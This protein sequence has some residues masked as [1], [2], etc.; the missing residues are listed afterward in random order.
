MVGH[1]AP[2]V[3][4]S[5]R[6]HLQAKGG[7]EPLRF[8]HQGNVVDVRDVM[9]RNDGLLRHVTEGGQFRARLWVERRG[10]P[11]HEDVGGDA[12][13]HE[14]LDGVLGGLGFL[15][16]HRPHH[17]NEGDV[18]EGHVVPADAELE[19]PEGL[20]VRGGFDVADGAA[21]LDDAH[22]RLETGVVAA[23]VRDGLDPIHDGVRDVW[24]D[25]N[26]FAEVIAAPFGFDDFRV[27]LSR[28]QVVVTSEV[29]IEE[30]LV[31]SKVEIDFPAV[32]EHEDL[33]VLERTHRSCV[34]VE[35]GVDF[36]GGDP[37]AAGFHQHANAAR[38]DAFTESAEDAT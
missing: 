4:E 23:L 21:Q 7:A 28:G 31:I 26:G 5:V 19:L 18:H 36:D 10:G 35:I 22:L 30:A 33:A 16:T 37:K 27:H 34:R 14:F 24:D 17:R 25:L 11:A 9:G 20:D 2:I 1:P 38:R 29:Q 8:E 15:F 13:P 6:L 12:Q 3:E 32:V